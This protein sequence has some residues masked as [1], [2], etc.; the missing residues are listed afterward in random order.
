[1]N[2]YSEDSSYLS[3]SGIQHFIFCKRQWGLIHI[4]QTW[5]ENE[6]TFE[7]ENVHQRAHDSFLCETREDSFIS[8]RFFVRSESLR[9]QG[10]TDVIQFIPDD[11]GYRINNHEGRFYPLIIEYKKGIP[12]EGI[13]DNA[14]L[15]AQA[16]S[17]EDM[18]GYS[19]K[20]GYIYYHSTHRRL[21]VDFDST[22]REK[23]TDTI[24]LMH[25]IY[26]TG[27]TPPPE[28]GPKCRN[29]SLMTKCINELSQV[30]ANLYWSEAVSS[31]K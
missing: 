24:N 10:Y 5:D 27:N 14:Q 12:K 30:N 4:E 1:L 18:M 13:E 29:C 22:L 25:K 3:I 19:L 23:V 17:L 31:L 28:K 15:C 8:R 7:G 26:L 9:I 2:E 21:R 20:Y 16:M 6:L 11:Q